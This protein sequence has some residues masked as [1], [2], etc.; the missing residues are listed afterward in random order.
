MLIRSIPLG[1]RTAIA[2]RML[3]LRN[4]HYAFIDLLVFSL[5]PALALYLRTDK[6]LHSPFVWPAL[7]IYT[8]LAVAIRIFTLH[9]FGL[10]QRYWRFVSAF[11]FA[12]LVLAN[13]LALAATSVACLFLWEVE[14]ALYLPRSLPIIDAML[15]LLVAGGVRAGARL[16]EHM[17]QPTLLP[18]PERANA[19]QRTLIVGAGYTGAQL[20]R[21]IRANH[22]IHL[23]LVGFIDDDRSKLGM[24]IHGVTVLGPKTALPALVTRH[25]I[26]RVIIAMP[27]AGGQVIRELVNICQQAQ[28][29]IQT[30]PGVDELLSGVVSVSRLRNVQIED[31]LRRAPVQTDIAAVKGLLHGKRVLVTGGGGSIGSELCRQIL[32]CQPAELIFLGHGENSVFEIHL[33]GVAINWQQQECR[34]EPH[35]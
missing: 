28:V 15:A 10:Y 34:R 18:P 27:S 35:R 5:T 21:E 4:R 13:S 20:A 26:E 1:L 7:A 12:Q 31:L 17:R 32:R 33:I 30:M 11:D 3:L 9:Y 23:Q 8:L 2:T 19:R 14:P 29:A 24:Q 16:T 22:N 6:L 25:Q